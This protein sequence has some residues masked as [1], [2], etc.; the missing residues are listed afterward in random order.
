MAHEAPPVPALTAQDLKLLAVFRAVAE[1]GGLTAAERRLGV[2]RS[3]I[4]RH[5]KRLEE[6]LGATLCQ[7]G[8]RGFELTDY[9]RL[10]AETAQEVADQMALARSRLA[11]ARGAITGELRLGVADNCLNNPRARIAETL[12]EIA[13]RAPS[14]ELHVTVDAPARLN[15]ALLARELHAVVNGAGPDLDRFGR[16][17]LFREEFRLYAAVAPGETVPHLGDLDR[18]GYGAVLR[19]ADASAASRAMQ[20]IG[21]A[22]RA[23]ASG[24][25]AAAALV[26]TG[27]FV[28]LL[29]THMVGAIAATR[30]LVE[31]RGAERFAF[32]TTLMLL[33]ERRRAESPLVVALR[34]AAVAAHADPAAPPQTPR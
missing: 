2:E 15:A 11:A 33:T 16:T 5:V 1:A 34:A 29:P 32:A 22:R 18:L 21:L 17:P 7:R 19:R 12:A 31:V 25:E 4:S 24:L 30:R 20:R 3:T 14:A 13:R 27:R 10:V 28:G 26:A 9:G 8:P 6:R 23:D